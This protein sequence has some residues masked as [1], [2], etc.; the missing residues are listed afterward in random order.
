MQNCMKSNGLKAAK[1]CF[2]VQEVFISLL[3]RTSAVGFYRSYLYTISLQNNLK[4]ASVI[5]KVVYDWA[6]HEFI[7]L[8]VSVYMR[9]L[10]EIG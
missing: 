2:S 1:R 5:Y 7:P 4:N 10:K 9:M 6:C 8:H 3:T